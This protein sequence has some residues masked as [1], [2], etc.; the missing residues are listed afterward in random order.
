MTAAETFLWSKIRMKQV[1]GH[2][3][4][5]QKPIGEYIADFY[6]PRAKLVIEVDGGQHFSSEIAEYDKARE[7]LRLL[8][9]TY[10]NNS[11]LIPLY[12]RGRLINLK[13]RYKGLHNHPLP[14]VKGELERDLIK[15]GEVEKMNMH[16]KPF[17]NLTR[18]F[19]PNYKTSRFKN[20]NNPDPYYDMF[21]KDIDTCCEIAIRYGLVIDEERGLLQGGRS[22]H[23]DS[24]LYELR[25]ARLFESYFGRGCLRWDPP[26]QTGKLGEYLLHVSDLDIFTEVKTIEKQELTEY[27]T[28]VSKENS[29]ENTLRKAYTKIKNGNYQTGMEVLNNV[30]QTS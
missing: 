28:L 13:H 21:R 23:E 8:R 4:Y 18:L 25:V 14:F 16:M 26:T 2:W 12:K 7:S 27:G 9:G 10:Y 19:H 29:I 24:T 15:G 17:N 5:R 22:I 11:P 30:H 1:K 6:C 3:F 20:L